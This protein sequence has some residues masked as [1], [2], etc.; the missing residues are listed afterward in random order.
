MPF[1]A[2]RF[3]NLFHAP[4]LDQ[5]CQIRLWMALPCAGAAMGLWLGSTWLLQWIYQYTLQGLVLLTVVA[6]M[7]L[8]LRRKDGWELPLLIVLPLVTAA[9]LAPLVY[10]HTGN[11]VLCYWT[12]MLAV[13]WLGLGLLRTLVSA[14]DFKS[15]WLILGIMGMACNGLLLGWHEDY[16]LN[17]WGFGSVFVLLTTGHFLHQLH[18]KADAFHRMSALQG[19]RS[20]ILHDLTSI[21]P[22]QGPS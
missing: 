18:R 17:Q 11:L 3:L 19:C 5:S 6:F 22:I 20:L 12:A 10:N 9:M 1:N 2:S 7:C 4:R 21:Q 16:T 8:M 14:F 15:E 13:C